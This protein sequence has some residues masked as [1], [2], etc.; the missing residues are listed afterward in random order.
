MKSK[1][2]RRIVKKHAQYYNKKWSSERKRWKVLIEDEAKNSLHESCSTHHFHMKKLLLMIIA[3][4]SLY[5]RLVPLCDLLCVE[6]FPLHRQFYRS[7]SNCT[8]DTMYSEPFFPFH[9]N[10]PASLHNFVFSHHS[11]LHANNRCYN[12]DR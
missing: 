8:L 2:K 4:T 1:K 3:F 12:Q 10:Q 6:C 9:L 5:I 11:R 7:Y